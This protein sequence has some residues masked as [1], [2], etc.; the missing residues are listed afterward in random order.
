MERRKYLIVG[1]GL[2]GGSAAESIREQDPSGDILLVAQEPHRPY[3]RPPLTKGYLRGEQGLDRV[4]LQPAPFYPEHNIEIRSSVRVTELI[5]G[6]RR[7]RLEDGTELGYE[8]LLLVTGGRPRR[9]RL[10]GADLPGVFTMRTIDDSDRIRTAAG[11]ATRAVVIGGGFIGSEVAASLAMM[12]K[13]V[14]LVFPEAWLQSR[15]APEELGRQLHQFYQQ[16]GVILYPGALVTAMEGTN[17]VERVV[18]NDGR[19][20]PADLVVLG[21]GIDLNTDLARRAGLELDAHGAIVVDEYLRTS[22]PNIY[23]GGDIAAWPDPTYGRRLRLEH[24][25]SAHGHGRQAGR[26]MAGA[27]EPYTDLPS[28]RTVLFDMGIRTWG[29]LETW[30]AALGRGSVEEGHFAYFHFLKGRLVGALASG[31]SE[32]EETAIPAFVAKRPGFDEV[33]AKLRDEGVSLAELAG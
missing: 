14:S 6:E 5:P 20:L 30:D 22:D 27:Q 3:Q 32:E 15:L 19:T 1:G 9:L 2:A 24:W 17:R 28:F 4:Y 16:R 21:V 10:P 18:L 23:S 29:D 12:G 7:V 33:Q 26:N 11:D 25:T 13:E 31:L 8:K